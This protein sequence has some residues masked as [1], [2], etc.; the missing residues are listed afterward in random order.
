MVL[1]SL[2]DGA[3]FT[4]PPSVL[5]QRAK[6]FEGAPTAQPAQLVTPVQPVGSFLEAALSCDTATQR[7]EATDVIDESQPLGTELIPDGD[8]EAQES[9]EE[10]DMSRGVPREVLVKWGQVLDIV[11]PDSCLTN[12]FT[13]TYTRFAKVCSVQVAASVLAPPATLAA[14]SAVHEVAFTHLGAEFCCTL[15]CSCIHC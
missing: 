11:T 9:V 1:Q 3:P 12:C 8:G 10:A 5:L 2:V 14:T 15:G 7:Q 4:E 6:L 13:K